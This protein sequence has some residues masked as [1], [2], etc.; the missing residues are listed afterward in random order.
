MS[1]SP[2]LTAQT[3]LLKT[4]KAKQNPLSWAWLASLQQL[5]GGWKLSTLPAPL[6]TSGRV[7]L[8]H[9]PAPTIQIN[10]VVKGQVLSSK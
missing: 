4:G 7:Y 2:S 3:L 10:V 6:L 8:S 5:M 1:L 9:T